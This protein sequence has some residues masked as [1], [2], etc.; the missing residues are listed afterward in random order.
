MRKIIKPGAA[1]FEL[2]C[3]DHV[4][5]L[6][7]TSATKH[8]NDSGLEAI[9]KFYSDE[10]I[11]HGAG[12]SPVTLILRPSISSTTSNKCVSV[13]W[14]PW[15]SMSVSEREHTIRD[16]RKLQPISLKTKHF[17]TSEIAPNIHVQVLEGNI[18]LQSES[19]DT[20]TLAGGPT[21]TI[22]LPHWPPKHGRLVKNK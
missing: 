14:S 5:A 18:A 19:V 7:A 17:Q 4:W 2:T 6:L 15:V 1:H 8:K 13:L 22:K 3:N 11:V 21:P 16:V 9:D 12:N 20:S 10:E